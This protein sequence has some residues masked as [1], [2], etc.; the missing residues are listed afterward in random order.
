M[1][2]NV[3]IAGLRDQKLKEK[4]LQQA[5]LKLVKEVPCLA[6]FCSVD[7]ASKFQGFGMIGG[8]WA[9]SSYKKTRRDLAKK[10]SI[11]DGMPLENLKGETDSE[12]ASFAFNAFTMEPQPATEEDT[13]SNEEASS[14][15]SGQAS[16]A[17]TEPE[18]ADSINLLTEPEQNQNKDTYSKEEDH[19]ELL[20]QALPAT[21][22]WN[23]FLRAEALLGEAYSVLEEVEAAHFPQ[24]SSASRPSTVNPAVARAPARNLAEAPPEG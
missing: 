7:K 5:I 23:L 24:G 17:G 1:V 3:T 15:L 11:S 20:T 4:C 16:P 8:I 10:Q 6:Q 19:S 18:A 2:F 12:L 9:I 21:K 14:S 13:S 22:T